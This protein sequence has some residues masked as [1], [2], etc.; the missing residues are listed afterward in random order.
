MTARGLGRRGVAVRACW[1]VAL[2]LAASGCTNSDNPSSE[3]AHTR[4]RIDDRNTSHQAAKRVII[5]VDVE[6][7][8]AR[9]DRDHVQRLI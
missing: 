4:N 7:L 1:L 9:Q 3:A 5:S 8:P 2:Y 6:A